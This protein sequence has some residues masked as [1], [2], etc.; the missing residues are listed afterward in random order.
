MKAE[1]KAAYE[2]L[3]AIIAEENKRADWKGECPSFRRKA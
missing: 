3:I 2:Q 1:Q